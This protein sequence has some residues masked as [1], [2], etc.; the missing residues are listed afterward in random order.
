MGYGG[1]SPGLRTEG[2]KT[3]LEQALCSLPPES[4]KA[5]LDLMET[6]LRNVIQHPTEEKFRKIR[7]TNEKIS[8]AIG[9]VPG[10]VDAFV[11]MGWQQQ[12]ENLVLPQNIK[13]DF[14]NHVNKVLEAKGY[15]AKA[16]ARSRTARTLLGDQPPV[17]AAP[18]VDAAQQSLRDLR[19]EQTGASLA[20]APAAAAP[21]PAPA[22]PITA[23]EAPKSAPV[24]TANNFEKK[25]DVAA[26]AKQS[27]NDID[28]LRA[29]RKQQ[30]KD[31]LADPN[32]RSGDAYKQPASTANGASSGGG[33]WFDGW[34]GSGSSSSN[35]KPQGGGGGE[36]QKPR[37]KT[38]GDLP[39]PVRRGG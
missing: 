9:Q 7:L 5:C 4:A 24:K 27:G 11:M 39:K 2:P 31:N 29:L 25:A 6:L 19:A 26:V 14:P 13:L 18:K 3:P 12:D 17:A 22:A 38:I 23:T 1:Y 37:M 10:A 21:A 33:G 34:F 15:F 16:E 36:R 20:P 35:S 8:K 30:F 32:G 28:D